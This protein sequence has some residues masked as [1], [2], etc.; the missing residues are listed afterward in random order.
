MTTY[1]WTA[2]N[3]FG[4]IVVREVPAESAEA[5]KAILLTQGYSEPVLK[6][7]DIIATAQ[8]GFP[9]KIKFMGEEVKVSSEDRIKGY[10][11][12]PA[13]IWS[14]LIQGINESKLGCF[15]LI[16][17]AAFAGYREYWATAMLLM[18]ALV[19]WLAFV[20]CLNLPAIYYRKLHLASDWNRWNEMLSL[21]N[22]LRTIGRFS[23]I[24]VPESELMRNRAKALTGLGRLDQALAEYN[25]FQGRPDCPSWLYKLHVGSLYVTAKQYD[26]A[27]ECNLQSIAEKPTSTAWADLANRYARYKH[28]PAKARAAMAEADKT[29]MPEFAKPF[30]IRCLGI[31]AYL[32]GDFASAKRELENAIGMMEKTKGRPFRDGNLA[33]ARAYLGCV[34]AKQGD[35][36][37]KRHFALAKEYLIATHEDELLAEC[38]KL[39]GD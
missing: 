6:E 18:V 29:P 11:A 25:Q 5:S 8:A 31:I 21:V 24:K 15:I 30:R 19:A 23:F 14:S 34:L 37:G 17:A 35:S 10:D 22:A 39:M 16:A 32:E 33:V 27:I 38:R 12:P 2:K 26:K 4:H 20:L 9:E 3:Q 28:D 36:A 7:D 13:T 1:V